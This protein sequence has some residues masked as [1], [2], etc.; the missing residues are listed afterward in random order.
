[1]GRSC[2]DLLTAQ[3]DRACRRGA[4]TKLSPTLY[5]HWPE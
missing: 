2:L 3:R 5:G 1:V 4:L